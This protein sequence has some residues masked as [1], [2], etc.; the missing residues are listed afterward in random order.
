MTEI[1]ERAFYGCRSL[2]STEIPE[3]VTEIGEYAF[4][5]CR[6]LYIYYYGLPGVIMKK[7]KYAR[8]MIARGFVDKGEEKYSEEVR[9]AYEEFIRNERKKL[10][11]AAAD[12]EKMMRYM[13]RK[14]MI[15]TEDIEGLMDKTEDIRVRAVLLE[16]V[17]SEFTK[18]EREKAFDKKFE[19]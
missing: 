6:S 19:I 18:E 5:G 16:Y 17:N 4:L 15:P 11:D 2:E 1:G 9:K 12:D 14:K 8:C 10:Y 13:C 3:G 7:N